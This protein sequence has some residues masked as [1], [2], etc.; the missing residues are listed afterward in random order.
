MSVV[1]LRGATPSGEPVPE[2]VNLCEAL[3]ERAKSGEIQGLAYAITRRPGDGFGTGWEG[4][5][6]FGHQLGAA[7]GHL[8]HR[9]YAGFD[10]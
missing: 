7:V 8:F 1:S 3:L 10:E 2:I 5:A 9:Y 6:G 4:N